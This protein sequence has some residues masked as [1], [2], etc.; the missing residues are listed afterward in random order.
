MAS[1][2]IKRR[3]VFNWLVKHSS[4]NSIFMLQESHGTALVEQ[5]WRNQW[6]SKM[7]FSH[8][9]NSSTGV[10]IC[11]RED[12]DC[13]V[14]NELHDKN[15]RLLVCDIEIQSEH[16]L[17][18]NYCDNNDQHGQLETFS[19]LESLFDKINFELDTKIILGGD[20]M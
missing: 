7:F 19:V 9:T 8:G 4:S 13:K 5:K 10:L 6:R 2:A 12:L 18:I 1:E 17:I 16:Y 11:I 20:V 14:N 15:G 3:K